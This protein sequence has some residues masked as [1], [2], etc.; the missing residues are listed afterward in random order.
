MKIFN[1]L[2]SLFGL[3]KANKTSNCCYVASTTK[4]NITNNCCSSP[5]TKIEENHNDDS[6]SERIQSIK[7]LGAGCKACHEQYEYAKQAVNNLCLDIEVE[8]ITDLN[9]VMKY[10]VISMPAIVIN[11]KIVSYGKILKVAEIER[12]L[13]A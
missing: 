6:L 11:E 5:N 10:S 12:I 7:V 1:L 8:Y 3:N 2:K 4:Q 13:K 9:K